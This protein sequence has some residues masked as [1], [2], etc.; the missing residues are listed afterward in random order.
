MMGYVI[1]VDGGNTKT[2]YALFSNEGEMIRF[3]HLGTASHERFSGGF[4]DASRELSKGI[5]M[6]LDGTG[7]KA[8]DVSCAVFGLAGADTSEQKLELEARISKIGIKKNMVCNDA[9]LG[10]KAGTIKGYGVCSNNGTAASCTAIDGHGNRIQIGGTGYFY[11]DE[12]GGSYIEG[13][14]VRK[15]YDSC[16]RRGKKTMM[17]DMLFEELK[18]SDDRLLVETA[19]KKIFAEGN[20]KGRLC[21]IAFLAAEEGDGPAIEILEKSGTELASSVAGAVDR[22]DF[23]SEPEIEVVMAGSVFVKAESPVLKEIFMQHT[24]KHLDNRAVFRLLEVP[25]VS[26]AVIWALDA[27]Y[28][29]R[30]RIIEA[31]K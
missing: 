17:K 10:I 28:D 26:G 13:M 21:Y 24:Q 15:V 22:L 18:I 2:H 5:D 16:F 7:I 19:E 4:D 29:I 25:P 30:K 6:L 20:K 23:K 3:I 8:A 14:V 27:G 11:G 9:Y 1:G 31:F 12:A